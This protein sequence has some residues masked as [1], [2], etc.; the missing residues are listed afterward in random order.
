MGSFGPWP[1]VGRFPGRQGPPFADWQGQGFGR[2]MS[3]L[4]HGIDDAV[5]AFTSHFT[6]PQNQNASSSESCFQPRFDVKEE[7]SSYELR[8]EL[9]DVDSKDL[10]VQFEGENVLQIRGKTETEAADK[11]THEA[12]PVYENAA[13]PTAQQDESSRRSSTSSYIKPTVEDEEATT[14]TATPAGEPTPTST[15]KSAS[16][17][18]EQ[19]EPETQR[20]NEPR[21]WMSE[22]KTGQF[23]RSFTFASRVDQEGIT[24]SLKNGIL[25]VT[26]PKAK[27]PEPRRIQVA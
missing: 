2:D 21:Y 10:E 6:P 17:P 3:S 27:A 5:E 11:S 4:F 9:P 14:S 19:A 22:R 16:A 20:R 26:V 8:G 18:A 7:E 13:E 15:E 24:A 23:K 25:K 1:A 12:P